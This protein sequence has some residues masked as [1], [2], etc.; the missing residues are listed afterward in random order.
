MPSARLVRKFAARIR[1]IWIGFSFVIPPTSNSG[2][3]LHE[4]DNLTDKRNSFD[5]CTKDG[6]HRAF[7]WTVYVRRLL[8]RFQFDTG[9][10]NSELRQSLDV[11]TIRKQER[12]G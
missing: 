2:A 5:E 9:C 1:S 3:E 8:L 12:A 11:P 7:W 10:C 6:Q 4:A